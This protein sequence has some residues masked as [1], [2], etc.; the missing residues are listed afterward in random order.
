MSGTLGAVRRRGL[1][2]I[3]VAALAAL[4]GGC[5]EERSASAYCETYRE[6]FQ[7]I[8]R[9]YPQIDQYESAN[10]IQT[11]VALPSALGDIAALIG[12]MAEA[13]PDEIQGDV[14]RVHENFRTQAEAVERVASDPIAGL[15]GVLT[16]GL[17]DSGA[18]ERMDKY[19]LANCG[20]HMFSGGGTG[21]ATVGSQQEVRQTLARYAAAMREK[22]YRT[23]C[24]LYAPDLIDRINAAGLPCEVAVRT[25][26]KDRRNPL[27]QVLAVEVSGAQASAR[28]R[29]TGDG[30][31]PS[32]DT[33]SL[34]RV[35]DGWKVA[36][37]SDG[38][39]T[40]P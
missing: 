3:S 1:I 21:N 33:V 34:V 16:R 17:M 36:S 12:E 6:G 10:P 24:G 29:S 40:S 23:V 27:L 20:E 25:G 19:T 32:T 5:G 9:Q 28:V 38:S 26:L 15:A 2:W 11:L 14:E 13:A 7:D 30:E 35:R 31:V 37:L 18:F 4:A 39:E 22:D 8:R